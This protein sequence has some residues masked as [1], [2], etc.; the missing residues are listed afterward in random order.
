MSAQPTLTTSPE[1]LKNLFG[2]RAGK[3]A[4]SFNEQ[5]ALRAL[6]FFATKRQSEGETLTAQETS[7]ILVEHTPEALERFSRAFDIL[8]SEGLELLMKNCEKMVEEPWNRPSNMQYNFKDPE[9]AE[10][11]AQNFRTASSILYSGPAQYLTDRLLTSFLDKKKYPFYPGQLPLYATIASQ[12]H[13]PEGALAILAVDEQRLQPNEWCIAGNNIVGNGRRIAN[14]D[15]FPLIEVAEAMDP[16]KSYALEGLD[17]GLM[18]NFSNTLKRAVITRKIEEFDCAAKIAALQVVLELEKAGDKMS[19]ERFGTRGE[20]PIRVD[21]YDNATLEDYSMAIVDVFK[22]LPKA[23]KWRPFEEGRLKVPTALVGAMSKFVRRT[24]TFLSHQDVRKYAELFKAHIVKCETPA[25]DVAEFCD[26]NHEILHPDSIPLLGKLL[27][28]T[29]TM[30][31]ILILE[32]ARRGTPPDYRKRISSELMEKLAVLDPEGN[33]ITVDEMEKLIELETQ[34]G[35]ELSDETIETLM[36]T[37]NSVVYKVEKGSGG[38]KISKANALCRRDILQALIKHEKENSTSLT[39]TAIVE[40]C[41]KTY[42]NLHYNGV[43]TTLILG[44]PRKS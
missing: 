24:G 21:F 28:G 30:P 38:Y 27:A 14:A 43:T 19:A 42:A 36:N 20:S 39:P 1:L 2:Y 6:Y 12:S 10:A 37:S 9:L 41:N 13:D 22:A 16:R 18:S 4:H 5:A 33:G 44:E 40:W 8:R 32:R 17:I 26:K 35:K 29:E 31:A 11:F 25:K 23:T 7:K 3:D 34:R 15:W